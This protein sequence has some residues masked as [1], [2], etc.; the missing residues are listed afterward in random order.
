MWKDKI[1]FKVLFILFLFASVCFAGDI[2]APPPLPDETPVEQDYFQK[3]YNN[4]NN[5]EVVTTN[6]DGV[7]SGKKGDMLFLITGG[8]YYLEI[9]I[10][11]STTWMGEELTDTP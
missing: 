3:I 7:T 5:L 2:P 10:D 4:W 9:N 1:D 8:K 6:P 11:G